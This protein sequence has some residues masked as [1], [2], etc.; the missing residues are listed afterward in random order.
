[1][2]TNF[3]YV[4]KITCALVVSVL[5]SASALANSRTIVSGET[6][7]YAQGKIIKI[8]FV[9]DTTLLAREV[10]AISVHL[11]INRAHLVNR[12]ELVACVVH[13][14]NKQEECI[15]TVKVELGATGLKE[16]V[17][18]G[19]SEL[20]GSEWDFAY[21]KVNPNSN[22]LTVLGANFVE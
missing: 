13:W 5:V 21:V 11:D 17:L 12:V 6:A 22:G 16:I 14:F 1:M 4:A 2:K 18:K 9:S 3:S 10:N 7:V 15:R 8:D 20:T 19:F